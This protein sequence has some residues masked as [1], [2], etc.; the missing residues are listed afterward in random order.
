[1]TKTRLRNKMGIKQMISLKKVRNI[2]EMK[3]FMY[4]VMIKTSLRNNIGIRQTISLYKVM[5]KKVECGR[6]M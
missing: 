6:H 3:S 5:N 4:W 2:Q 1:M